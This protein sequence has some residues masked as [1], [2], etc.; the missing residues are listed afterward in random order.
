MTTTEMSPARERMQ[1]DAAENRDI[2]AA[3]PMP[4][5]SEAT[6]DM[7][8]AIYQLADLFELADTHRWLLEHYEF[9]DL[10]ASDVDEARKCLALL[11][12]VGDVV[13]GAVRANM[14]SADD[15]ET[16]SALARQLV[17]ALLGIE[18]LAYYVTFAERTMITEGRPP[19]RWPS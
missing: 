2:L 17:S 3:H 7:V 15:H 9:H 13:A 4:T 12:E 16:V 18:C 5:A 1:R 14:A 11:H 6:A 19:E 8:S 10:T